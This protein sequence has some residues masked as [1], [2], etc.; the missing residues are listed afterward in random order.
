MGLL[1]IY[2]AIA[3][4]VSFLCSVLEAILLSVTP[5]YVAAQ[6]KKNPA[7]GHRL[8]QL[9]KDIN[10]PLAAIL[11]LNTIAHTVGAAGAG[12][13]AASVF[14]DV[15]LG[16]ASA[17]LTLLILVFSEIIPK[18]LGAVYWRQLAP[19][20]VRILVVVVWSMWPLV[21]LAQ[22]ITAG[23]S[24]GHENTTVR[25]EEIAAIAEVGH[26]QG[27]LGK[28]ESEMMKSL[29]RFSKLT[30]QDVMTPRTVMFTLAEDKTVA[31]VLETHNTLPFSRIPVYEGTPDKITGYV[32]KGNLLL[33][34]ARDHCATRLSEMRHDLIAVADTQP[35]Y[36]VL[37][38]ILQ[39]R[40][41][42]ALVVDEY[43]GVSG[44]ITLEDIVETLLGLEIVDESDT[45]V[46]MQS[47]ARELWSHRAQKIGVIT[48]QEQ[49][50]A[51][52]TLTGAQKNTAEL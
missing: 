9:K 16:I 14:G 33:T 2:V 24:A 31:E 43:G 49:G 30:A 38:R 46:D 23:L 28:Q 40:E 48:D 45:V 7:F 37:E 27:V 12:A 21:R 47:H 6:S 52:L 34:A 32:L 20:M 8:E 13:Q 50:S 15:Y 11:S 22:Y 36:D 41:H 29:L 10:K 5:G 51:R 17:V 44:L 26:K 4:G 3:L 25:R 35:L 1:L 39:E 42:I 18:T 19:W